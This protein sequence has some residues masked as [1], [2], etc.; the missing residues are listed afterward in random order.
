MV[1]APAGIDVRDDA[2]LFDPRSMT[3]SRTTKLSTPRHFHSA[4]KLPSGQVVVIGGANDRATMLPV[5][6]GPEMAPFAQAIASA[7]VYDATTGQ[8]HSVGAMSQARFLF[9]ATALADG[10]VLVSAGASDVDEK[11]FATTD[12]LC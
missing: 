11:S 12:G 8:W 10:R 6:G 4:T 1:G 9:Q 3:W 5:F 2:L 7:E